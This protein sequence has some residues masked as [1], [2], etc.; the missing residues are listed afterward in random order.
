MSLR[1]SAG[2]IVD[3]HVPAADQIHARER[4]IGQHVVPGEDADVAD[5]L[6]D[7]IAAVGFHEEASQPLAR[8]FVLDAARE[9]PGA[10]S[11][12]V[13]VVEIGGIERERHVAVD[14]ARILRERD[15]ERI[16]FFAA[17]TAER[18]DA[19]GIVARAVLEQPREDSR[20]QRVEGL[21]GYG[22][23]WSR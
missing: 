13:R 2:S 1:W 4:R 16:R 23:S 6:A 7:P 18:P 22:R 11:L 21:R 5:R 15:R 8:H 14:L 19:D 12:H 9:Q 20:L 10:G 3:H 17:G